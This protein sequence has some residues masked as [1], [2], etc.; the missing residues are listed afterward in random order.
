LV[1]GHEYAADQKWNVLSACSVVS[2]NED[3]NGERK[4]TLATTDVDPVAPSRRLPLLRVKL[5]HEKESTVRIDVEEAP[6]GVELRGDGVSISCAA[7]L[8]N[9]TP[10][11]ANCQ[12]LEPRRA[13]YRLTTRMVTVKTIPNVAACATSNDCRGKESVVT[14]SAAASTATALGCRNP[15]LWVNRSPSAKAPA[16]AA[17]TTSHRRQTSTS[18]ELVAPRE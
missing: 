13:A 18:S 12:R 5:G 8:R 17:S 4:N 1:G 11:P 6:T 2:E 7:V 15:G 14:K 3:P 9:A 16:D 10:P